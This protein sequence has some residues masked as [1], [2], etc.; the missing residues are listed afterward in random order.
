LVGGKDFL[1][2]LSNRLHKKIGKSITLAQI[3]QEMR[4]SEVPID[5]LQV[6]DSIESFFAD[7]QPAAS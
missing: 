1:S 2:A 5:L 3:I 7:A 6:I 4:V